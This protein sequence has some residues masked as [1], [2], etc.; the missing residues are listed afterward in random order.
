[1][2]VVEIDECSIEYFRARGEG[3]WPWS[4]QRHADLLDQLDRAGVRAV[5]YDVL[6]ADASQE[7]PGGDLALDAM[8]EGGAGRFIFASTR[9]HPDYDAGSSMRAS[10]APGA[11]ALT[12]DP[13]RDPTVALLLPYG[14]AMTRFSAIAN[15]SRNEDGV[16]RDFSLRESAGDWALPSLPLRVAATHMRRP[17]DEFPRGRAAELA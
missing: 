11:F 7:D 8:A 6:F 4:R 10:K 17:Q 15:V 3:G 14:A 2:A 16:L 12:R 13:A 1:M 9:L 5:G